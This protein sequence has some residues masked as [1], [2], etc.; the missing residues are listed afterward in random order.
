MITQEE[1]TLLRELAKQ[2]R[3][4]AADDINQKRIQR[5]RDMHSLKTGQPLFV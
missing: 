5:S 4:L 2:V 1:K 3:D